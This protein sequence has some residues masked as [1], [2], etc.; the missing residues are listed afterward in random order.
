MNRKYFPVCWMLCQTFT[1]WCQ[2]LTGLTADEC[3]IKVFYVIPFCYWNISLCQ[4]HWTPSTVLA[5][6]WTHRYC[7]ASLFLIVQWYTMSNKTFSITCN[8]TNVLIHIYVS[9]A[10]PNTI[11]GNRHDLHVYRIAGNFDGGKYWRIGFIQKLTGEILT[12]SLLDNL[13]LI[14]LLYN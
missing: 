13:Y 1:G 8:S 7:V 4:H 5:F 2:C 10:S 11:P 6:L 12:D 3:S 14:N 9:K